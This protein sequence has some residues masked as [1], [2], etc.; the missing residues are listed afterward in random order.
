MSAAS[1]KFTSTYTRLLQQGQ[2]PSQIAPNVDESAFWYETFALDVNH[3]W[4][5][6][7]LSGLPKEQCLEDRRVRD[8]RC[9]FNYL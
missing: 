1:F 2:T 4:L 3:A 8:T 9:A 7:L 6:Q 5:L